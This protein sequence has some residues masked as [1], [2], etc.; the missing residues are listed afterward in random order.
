MIN[1]MPAPVGTQT[2]T[3]PIIMGTR[4][5]S[6][7]GYAKYHDSGAKVATKAETHV[8]RTP[9]RNPGTV[10]AINTENATI[11]PNQ[12]GAKMSCI[13]ATWY[14]PKASAITASS[15]NANLSL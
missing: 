12:T 10:I 14:P 8:V 1:P 3:S 5:S 15:E 6:R 4:N 2:H 13:V 7:L 11:K 9:P